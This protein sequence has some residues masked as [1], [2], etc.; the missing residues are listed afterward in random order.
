M[1]VG[2]LTLIEKNGKRNNIK[3]PSKD[4]N[5]EL[6]IMLCQNS[7]LFEKYTIYCGDD[8]KYHYEYHDTDGSAIYYDTK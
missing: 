1:I 4:V 5:M 8:V 3:L 2:T 6:F 7:K